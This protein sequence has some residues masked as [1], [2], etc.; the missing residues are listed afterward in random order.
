MTSAGEKILFSK[1]SLLLFL[2][3]SL[4]F[5]IADGATERADIIVAKDGSGNFST[6]QAA[7]DS[8]PKN[9]SRTW[10]ILVKRGTYNEKV[11][12]TKDNIAI[13]GEDRDSTRIVYAEL[14]SNWR[15]NNSS[16]IGAAVISLGNKVANLTLANLT[17]YNNYGALNGKT[18]HQFAI[19]GGGNCTKII[20][21]NCNVWADG[22]DTM[23]LWN[24]ASGMY[25]HANCDFKGYVDYV[26]PRGWCYITDSRFY[27]YNSSASI[28]HDGSVDSTSKFVIRN[29]M[30]DGIPNFPLGRYHKDA[31]FY[32]LDCEFS[33]NMADRYIYP[34]DSITKYKWG[35]RTYYW[36]CHR[37]GGDYKWFQDNLSLAY[38]G[39]VKEDDVT[40]FW[41]FKGEWDPERT[42][43]AI[44]PFAGI[45]T[46][47][48]GS[49]NISSTRID[50]LRWIGGRNAASYN[51]YLG[52]TNT[53]AFV[54]NQKETSYVPGKLVSNTTY[55][56]RVDVVTGV[57]TIVGSLW[58][59]TTK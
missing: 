53:P 6:V 56:W 1:L 32:L 51:I 12:I 52:N 40:A 46:P 21:V 15:L 58:S 47:R 36:N 34:V 57:D 10:I 41:T 45:P 49:K 30:F 43:P 23:S 11:L 42:M 26:C 37:D 28:W 8:V 33:K 14:R 13:V 17:I 3:S 2:I 9:A 7:V 44:L 50:S 38:G 48:N 20:V 39:T 4:S 24:P 55:Y 19:R 27:G 18:D 54:R 31:Q 35:Q 29:S 16:D 5:G 22:G 25:Y 59:F